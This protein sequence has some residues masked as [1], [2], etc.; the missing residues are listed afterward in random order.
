MSKAGYDAG[1][2]LPDQFKIFD[3][4]WMAT[5]MVIATGTY[6]M[7]SSGDGVVPFPYP[8]HYAPAADVYLVSDSGQGS[9]DLGGRFLAGYTTQ[10]A[11][12]ITNTNT[13]R[14]RYVRYIIWAVSI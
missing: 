9:N 5:G 7:P 6:Q 11:L 10:N 13:W 8:L 1:A 14:N 2:G 12:V 3:S 4:N